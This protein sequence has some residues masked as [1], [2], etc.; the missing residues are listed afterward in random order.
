MDDDKVFLNDISEARFDFINAIR[1]HKGT[2]SSIRLDV[3]LTM[4]VLL[5]M[6][7][8]MTDRIKSSMSKERQ[9]KSHNH[10]YVCNPCTETKCNICEPQSENCLKCE[11][12]MK[13]VL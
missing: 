6:Y 11:I 8:R 13:D 9:L 2:E 3:L 7:D 1:K 4:Y 5:A 10:N 12:K